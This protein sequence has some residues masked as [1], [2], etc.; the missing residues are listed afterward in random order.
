MLLVMNIITISPSL[1]KIILG[2]SNWSADYFIN[3]AGASIVIQKHG[4]TLNSEIVDNLN[5]KIF[6]RDWNS[7]YASPLSDFD[8]EGRRIRNDAEVS[9]N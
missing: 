9:M 7:T 2:T 1:S 8:D 5:D 6:M 4:R 3:T